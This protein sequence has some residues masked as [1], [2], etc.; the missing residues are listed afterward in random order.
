MVSYLL[1]IFEGQWVFRVTLRVLK[2]SEK[3]N[4]RFLT[5]RLISDLSACTMFMR[6]IL[7]FHCGVFIG[8]LVVWGGQ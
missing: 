7:R 8:T 3:P 5:V 1:G 6:L 2:S 4:V